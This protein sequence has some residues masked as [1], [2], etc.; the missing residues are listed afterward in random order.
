M[1]NP[2]I[3]KAS[4]D[5]SATS[6]LFVLNLLWLHI[7]AYKPKI[8]AEILEAESQ[9]WAAVESPEQQTKASN[10][11]LAARTRII[12][13]LYPEEI[14][15][16]KNQLYKIFKKTIT[17]NLWQKIMGKKIELSFSL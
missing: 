3:K 4:E 15:T 8:A 14:E 7:L 1:E 12:G 16:I 5:L 17:P 10:E 9:L 6:H 13:E 2:T 11:I